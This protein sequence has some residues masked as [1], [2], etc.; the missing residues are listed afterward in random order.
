MVRRGSI[1]ARAVFKPQRFESLTEMKTPAN[2]AGIFEV[3]GEGFGQTSTTAYRFV[4]VRR[5]P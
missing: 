5:L 4:E 2:F 1:A 3:A